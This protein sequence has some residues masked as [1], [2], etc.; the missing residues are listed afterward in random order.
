[1]DKLKAMATFVRI[2][3]SGS[4]SAAADALGQ[5]PAS[6]VRTLSALERALGVRL[7]NRSTRRL[8]LTD[9]GGEYLALSRRVL[10]EV[11]AGE[12]ALEARRRAPAGALRITAP[13]EFGR[14]HIAPLVGRFLE[15]HPAVRAELTLLDCMVDLLDEGLDLAFRIGQLPDSSLV[16]KSIGRTRHVVCASPDLLRRIGPLDHPSALAALPCIAFAPQGRSWR[17]LEDGRPLAVEITPRISTNQVQAARLACLEGLGVTRLLHYQVAE[18]L[19]AGRLI[20]VLGAFEMPA[21]PIQV[22]YPHARLL[23]ARV[24]SFID[25]AVPRLNAA[26]PDTALASPAALPPRH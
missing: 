24:R 1:M 22:I 9:E 20:R 23:S 13:V 6:V 10:A 12:H 2:V 21:L 11:E 14:L 26:I 18:D 17:F 25:W 5:S 19:A 3:D 7:L 16:A 8:A 15:E 4:L